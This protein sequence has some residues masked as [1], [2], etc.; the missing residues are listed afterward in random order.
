MCST[1]RTLQSEQYFFILFLLT[2]NIFYRTERIL[3]ESGTTLAPPPRTRLATSTSLLAHPTQLPH[4]T[5]QCRPGSPVATQKRASGGA[6]SESSETERKSLSKVRA[7][8]E[9]NPSRIENNLCSDCAQTVLGLCSDSLDYVQ[10]MFRL[11]G[12]S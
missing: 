12:L 8:S 9:Q 4:Q 3:N 7:K 1:E 10:T 6:D 5:C 2:K 11:F